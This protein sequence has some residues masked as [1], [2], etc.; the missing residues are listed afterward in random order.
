MLNSLKYIY[1]HTMKRHPWRSMP[2]TTDFTGVSADWFVQKQRPY[3][4]F[5]SR[6]GYYLRYY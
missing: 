1:H 6:G 3:H 2:E 4:L 5:Y